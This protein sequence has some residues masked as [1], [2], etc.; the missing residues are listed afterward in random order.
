MPVLSRAVFTALL[1]HAVLACDPGFDI[2]GTVSDKFGAPIASVTV[3]LE[4]PVRS[5]HNRNVLTDKSGKF[6][7]RRIGCLER[8][9][10]VSMQQKGSDSKQYKVRDYCYKTHPACGQGCNV[11]KIDAIL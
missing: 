6:Q 1:C 10:N 3:N 11:V 7:I 9:C 5:H 2:S 4:C 8:D